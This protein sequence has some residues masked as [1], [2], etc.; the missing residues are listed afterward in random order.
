[1]NLALATALVW[2]DRHSPVRPPGLF[3]A[4][5]VLGLRWNLLLAIAAHGGRSGVVR[6]RAAPQRPDRRPATRP[7]R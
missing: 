4:A 6:R 2:L 3:A 5:H 7:R 1:L